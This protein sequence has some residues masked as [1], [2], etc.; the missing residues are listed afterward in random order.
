MKERPAIFSGPMPCAVLEGRK[1]QTRRIIKNATG[2]FWDHAG[3]EPVIA[4]CRLRWSWKATGEL[5]EHGPSP[6]CPY[7]WPGD[8]IWVREACWAWG[9]WR[10]NGQTE[11]GRQRWRFHAD[12]RV[13]PLFE[14]PTEDLARREGGPGWAYRHARFM[15]RRASRIILRVTSVR[16]ERLQTITDED[17]I[18]EGCSGK[19]I[20]PIGE[21]GTIYAWK[22]RSGAA[23]PRAHF[24]VLWE[25]I[26]GKR[27]PWSN[28]PWVWVIGFERVETDHGSV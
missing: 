4:A 11:T 15:P 24:A 3:Y 17:A 27:A 18:A 16:V 25:K 22:G 10:R 7:G 8:K 1:L 13:A 23:S 26:N 14:K 19:D 20:E 5:S 9:T 6:L 2:A 28:N 21:G 12:D